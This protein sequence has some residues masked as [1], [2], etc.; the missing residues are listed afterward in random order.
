ME[1]AVCANCGRVITSKSDFVWMVDVI[2]GQGQE[3][4][5][6]CC[7]EACAIMTQEHFAEIHRKR[8]EYIER[9]RFE[10]SLLMNA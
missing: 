7:C 6:P 3:L 2:D 5:K 9:Q 10:K 8:A 1:K 4:N